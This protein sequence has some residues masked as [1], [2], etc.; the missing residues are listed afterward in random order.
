MII[1]IPINQSNNITSNGH[2]NNNG[3]TQRHSNYIT[4]PFK[5]R[6]KFR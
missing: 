5:R 2:R 1:I 3:L 6:K 4:N